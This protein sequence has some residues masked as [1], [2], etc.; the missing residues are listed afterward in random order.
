MKGFTSEWLEEHQA[1]KGKSK[2]IP[3]QSK[4][5]VKHKFG[6]VKTENDGFKFDSK[7]EARY[8]TCLKKLRDVTGEIRFFL[9]QAPFHLPGNIRCVIDFVVFWSDGTV[10]FED[11]KGVETPRFKLKR[12]QVESLFPVELKTITNK[13]IKELEKQL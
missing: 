8:Y 3:K 13:D 1:K 9:R 5:P 6:A 2:P 4:A 12:T 10:T 7:M 11:V